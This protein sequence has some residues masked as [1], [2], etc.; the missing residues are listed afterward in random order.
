[1]ALARSLR[2]RDLRQT[3]STSQAR[4]YLTDEELRP[5][6][7][8]KRIDPEGRFS[9]ASCCARARC[10]PTGAYTPS[11]SLL[12]AESLI[13]SKAT[14]AASPIPSE[15]LRCGSASRSAR[16][17][18]RQLCTRPATNPGSL[19]IEAFL[20]EEQTRLALSLRI[21]TSSR[22]SPTRTVCHKCLN[23]CPVDID[24]GNVSIAMRN[25]LRKE[26]K[27]KWSP[28]PPSRW[29]SS[30]HRPVDDQL[31]KAGMIDLAT[32]RAA[33]MRGETPGA[34]RCADAAPAGDRGQA[35]AQAQVIPLREQADARRR[36]RTARALLDIEDDNVVPII[37]D[38]AGQRRFGGVLL[39]GLRFG[40]L[41]SQV[42][43]RRSVLHHVGAQTVLRQATCAAAIRRPRPATTTKA[44]DHY[45]QPCVVPPVLTRS[46]TSTSRPSSCRAARAD[47]L[48]YSSTDLPGCRLLDIHEYLM[49]KGVR[50]EGGRRAL[51]VPRP[52]TRR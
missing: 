7:S 14:S 19:L 11:F 2:R 47:Q 48:Q 46:T 39:P 25:L 17:T 50:L 4:E 9:R 22:T 42:G 45:R 49:E 32:A 31:L 37:R 18:C 28:V 41:F 20:Y 23:P 33:R 29:P 21:S 6:P 13:S 15:L 24:F 40:R 27:R 8:T 1:M 26:G 35:D 10:R 43:S 5:L 16:R 52:A 38:P 51:H 3:A 36:K 30:R 44:G 34:R 12:G